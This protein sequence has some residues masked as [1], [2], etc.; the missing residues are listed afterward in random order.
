MMSLLVIMGIPKQYAIPVGLLL[1]LFLVYS[2]LN[3]GGL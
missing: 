2:F 3:S 1:D